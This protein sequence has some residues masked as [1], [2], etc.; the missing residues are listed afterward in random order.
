[1]F[2]LRDAESPLERAI[3]RL[4]QGA[5]YA[6][7]MAEFSSGIQA[8]VERTQTAARPSAEIRGAVLRA[9]DGRRWIEGSAPDLAASSLDR[10]VDGILRSVAHG[11][12]PQRPVPGGPSTARGEKS[13]VGARRPVDVP[14]A[15]HVELSRH[16]YEIAKSVDG[17]FN[18][19]CSVSTATNERLFLSSAGARLYQSVD[20]GAVNVVPVARENGRVEYTALTEGWTGGFERAESFS[21]DGVREAAGTA[22]ALLKA[23]A[24]PTGAM[25][26]LLDPG[27]A[28][29]LAHESFGHGTEADQ[30]MR[31]RSYLKPLLGQRVGPEGLTLV[32]SGV[33]PA[34][35]GSMSFDDEGTEAQRTVMVD[36]G[37]FRQM[38][39]DRETAHALGSTP[40]GNS[41]RADYLSRAFVRMT[42]T[43]VEPGDWSFEELVREAKDG[44]VLERVTSGM[45]DPLGGQ[46]QIKTHY[47]HRIV[48][49]E[50]GPLV[51]GMALSGRVL[52]F[53]GAIRGVG[54]KE[55]FRM[56]PGFCGKGHTDL[57]PAGTGGTYVLSEGVVGTA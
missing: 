15:E 16:W 39:H 38:L 27:T 32:D 47:G 4:S 17:I 3:V 30:A 2:S 41:R 53:L 24:P 12:G 51:S 57:L 55:Y 22:L 25:T 52:D 46:M 14:I 23:E 7:A 31:D 11:T 48:H 13:L 54:K 50:L 29:V 43:Y 9:W 5:P 42:N 33:L 28:G 36:R 6:D 10:A 56:D 18:A 26:V 45:E 37:V 40:T 19:I 21:E 44:V 34:G 49:G 8:R 35:W 20:R 1:M